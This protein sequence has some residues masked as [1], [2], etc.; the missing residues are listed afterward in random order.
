MWTAALSGEQQAPEATS[1]KHTTSEV[2]LAAAAQG[3]ILT[4]VKAAVNRAGATGFTKMTGHRSGDL[5]RGC[6]R[7]KRREDPW[8]ARP[9]LTGVGPAWV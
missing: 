7:A 5:S 8:C 3:A 1:A 2:L 9:A 4:V 6:L